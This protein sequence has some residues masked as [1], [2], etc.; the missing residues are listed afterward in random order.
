MVFPL[1]KYSNITRNSKTGVKQYRYFGIK[2][3]VKNE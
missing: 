3:T 2:E 1:Y